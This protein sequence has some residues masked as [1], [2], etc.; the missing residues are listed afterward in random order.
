MKILTNIETLE[1]NGWTMDSN[2]THKELIYRK[3]LDNGIYL[4]VYKRDCG[5][6]KDPMWR[7]FFSVNN[8]NDTPDNHIKIAQEFK[9]IE[10]KEDK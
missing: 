1:K 8:E 5:D 3:G 9:A 10:V 2:S 4:T 7:G 6:E